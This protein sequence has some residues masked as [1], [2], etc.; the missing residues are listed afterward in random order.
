MISSRLS[1]QLVVTLEN[2]T[3]GKYI[4]LASQEHIWILYQDNGNGRGTEGDPQYRGCWQTDFIH[5]TQM[6][7]A[8][9]IHFNQ[10]S[11]SV[12]VWVDVGGLH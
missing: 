6:T 11:T 1:D 4:L 9:F 8:L 7:L 12:Y 5:E 2:E 10:G 3:Q